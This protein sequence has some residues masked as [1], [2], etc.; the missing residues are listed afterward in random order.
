MGR[1]W[2]VDVILSG[3][4]LVATGLFKNHRLRTRYLF[5]GVGLCLMGTVF[6]L[7]SADIVKVSFYSVF[8][9]WWPL[10]LVVLGLALVVL[11]A[12]Q[13][14]ADIPFP[15]E[16]EDSSDSDISVSGDGEE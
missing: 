13:Q 15:Y 8:R 2:P 9:R 1:L 16:P 3:L 11:F 5:P 10:L 6:L 7:F 12:C 14:R 4:C